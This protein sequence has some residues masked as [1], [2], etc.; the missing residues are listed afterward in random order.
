MRTLPGILLFV[1][2]A[3]LAQPFAN[4]EAKCGGLSEP[5]VLQ[6]QQIAS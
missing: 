2:L 5:E 6:V 1:P 4:G 3:A